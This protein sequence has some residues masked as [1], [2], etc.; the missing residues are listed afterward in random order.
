M[1]DTLCHD[2]CM[3]TQTPRT[4]GPLAVLIGGAVA[5]PLLL[6]ALAVAGVFPPVAA[7]FGIAFG[8]LWGLVGTAGPLRRRLQRR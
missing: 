1:V 6:L 2:V 4:A 7:I 8:F 3:D 5:I